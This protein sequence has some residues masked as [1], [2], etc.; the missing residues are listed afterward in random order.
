VKTLPVMMRLFAMGEP[1]VWGTSAGRCG[2]D[3]AAGRA[4]LSFVPEMP[5]E[6]LAAVR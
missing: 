1:A 4:Y 2:A 6:R 3:D 5:H